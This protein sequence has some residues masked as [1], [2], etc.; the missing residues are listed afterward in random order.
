LPAERISEVNNTLKEQLKKLEY[1]HLLLYNKTEL[2]LKTLEVRNE[3][4]VLD[5]D[6]YR[7][8]QNPYIH[9]SGYIFRCK[10]QNAVCNPHDP[11]GG[12]YAALDMYTFIPNPKKDN[13]LSYNVAKGSKILDLFSVPADMETEISFGAGHVCIKIKGTGSVMVKESEKHES[14]Q[15]CGFF[16]NAVADDISCAKILYQIKIFTVDSGIV[17]HDSGRADCTASF[18]KY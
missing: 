4:K 7:F 2:L 12:G 3:T 15:T 16:L 1:L 13:F 8:K 17:L 6:I 5:D 11:Y 18:L 10:A 9:T 14:F